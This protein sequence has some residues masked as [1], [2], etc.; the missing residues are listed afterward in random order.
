MGNAN[1]KQYTYELSIVIPC[2]NESE[3][4]ELCI[5]KA[6]KFLEKEGIAG[7][8][9]VADNA[10]TDDSP[11]IAARSGARV[12][13]IEEK[14]YGSALY[15]GISAAFG[16]Y[17]IMGDAD[18]SYDFKN[19]LPFVNKLREG[20]DLV[21]GNRFKGG[22]EPKAMPFLHQ[23][24]GNPVL[25]K[26]GQILFKSPCGDF[27][28]GLRGF[29]KE[30]FSKMDLRTKG[31]EFAIEMVVKA[32]LLNMRIAEVPTTL[33]P[34][35]RS[36]PSHLRTWR[37]GWRTLRFLLLYSPNW[38][39]L[40]PGIL[41]FSLGSF[42]VFLLLTGPKAIGRVTFDIRSLLFAVMAVILGFQSTCFA[43]VSKT[44]AISEGLL[45]IST[46]LN[47]LFHYFKLEIGLIIG[48]VLIVLGVLFS[49]LSL[50]KWGVHSFGPLDYSGN[51]RIVI[52]SVTFLTLGFQ[53]ILTSFLISILG[54]KRK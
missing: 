14:G 17:I 29:S 15:G 8:I 18:G 23:Y 10:S 39:F 52:L 6:K 49:T 40:Y 3:T 12:V 50:A 36:H 37:D 47:V 31:M 32:S 1:Q 34:D 22:I 27:Y 53:V 26:T 25:T 42:F 41:L 16:K 43:V 46:R 5:Q 38:L 7:E 44:F 9:I 11:Q 28:C 2:L 30:A 4:I 21:M 20:Y 48:T 24:L 19:L 13:H 51:M 54:L 33:S 45:P 35:G